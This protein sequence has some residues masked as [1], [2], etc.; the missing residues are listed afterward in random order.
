MSLN[1]ESTN[2]AYVLGRL[3][4]V[5]EKAQKDAQPGINTTI[6][7]RYFTSACAAPRATF[8]VLLKLAQHHM[9][10]TEYGGVSERRVAELMDKLNVENDPFPAQLGLEQQ[11]L[12]VLGYYHQNNENYRS[13][14][15]EN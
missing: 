7:D 8:P 14:K 11:G 10:K 3:F 15:E 1:K 6:K 2:Q 13:K 5:L 12:F 4:A 9:A